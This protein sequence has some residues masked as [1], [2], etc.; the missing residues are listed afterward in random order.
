MPQDEVDEIEVYGSEAQ[1]GTQLATY[2][3]EV[4]LG[5]AVDASS[6]PAPDCC[7]V[8]RCVTACST[9]DPAPMLLWA[10]P[11]SSLKRCLGR[12]LGLGARVGLGQHLYPDLCSFRTALSQTWRLWFAPAMGRMGPC[13][14]CRCVGQGGVGACW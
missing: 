3:F 10:S 14:C 7:C 1:S 2:S 13:R 11:P 5:T 12:G 9:L 6:L 4:R 8:C